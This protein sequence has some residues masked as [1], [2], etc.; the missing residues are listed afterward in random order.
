MTFLDNDS[1]LS[2]W[3]NRDVPINFFIYII[4]VLTPL[5]MPAIWT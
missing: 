4:A 2:V 1:V 5:T 3:L